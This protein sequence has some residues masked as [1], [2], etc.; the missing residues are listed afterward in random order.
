[1]KPQRSVAGEGRGCGTSLTAKEQVSRAK[2]QDWAQM[3]EFRKCV[4]EAGVLQ[5]PREGW[6][7]LQDLT[8]RSG[9]TS[10]RTNLVNWCYLQPGGG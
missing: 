9:A 4:M 2:A 7:A 5:R 10:T 6:D 1:M 8:I 3:S